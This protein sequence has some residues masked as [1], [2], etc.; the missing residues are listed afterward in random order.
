MT[1]MLMFL[2]FIILAT[3]VQTVTGFAFGLVLMGLI[4]LSHLL[5]LADTAI[6]VSILTLTNAA[7]ILL[8][9]WR[10]VDIKHLSLTLA[11]AFP[12]VIIGVF[13][14]DWLA[15]TSLTLLQLILGLVIALSSFQLLQ[16]PKTGSQIAPNYSFVISGALG[17][18]LSGLFSAAAP[19]IVHHFY[20]QPIDYKI[21]RDTLLALFACT[22]ILRLTTVVISGSWHS[23]IIWWTL[24]AL[25]FVIITSYLAR[26]FPPPLGPE[27]IR[28]LVFLLLFASGAML[29]VPAGLT[30][31]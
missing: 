5:P 31:L 27:A 25:P 21:I 14:L 29:A 28:R 15:S 17:G 11:G 10:M 2:S 20:R 12:F 23:T 26:R 22:G 18:L 24:I 7:V 6:I 19:P 4:G 13:L 16:R 1:T 9:A 8:K 30:F 3:Y